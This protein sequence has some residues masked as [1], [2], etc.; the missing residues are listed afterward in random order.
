MDLPEYANV[1]APDTLQRISEAF[2]GDFTVED[3]FPELLRPAIHSILHTTP[4]PCFDTQGALLG[5][6]MCSPVFALATIINDEWRD[7]IVANIR[8]RLNAT[9]FQDFMNVLEVIKYARPKLDMYFYDH[10]YDERPKTA[11][12]ALGGDIWAYLVTGF[13]PERLEDADVLETFEEGTSEE[14]VEAW[15]DM[16]QAFD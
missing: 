5:F 9:A 12:L 6:R 11:L 1:F 7:Y 8:L 15:L 13:A 2:F 10:P 4:L 3:D 16:I 14:I